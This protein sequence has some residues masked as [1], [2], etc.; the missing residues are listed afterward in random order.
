[1][2]RRPFPLELMVK[3]LLGSRWRFLH[4]RCRLDVEDSVSDGSKHLDNP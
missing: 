3:V 4:G 2:F 1:M